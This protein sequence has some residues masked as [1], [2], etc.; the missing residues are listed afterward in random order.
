MAISNSQRT[1]CLRIQ[2]ADK[3][4]RGLRLS[5]EN[6]SDVQ[7]L[8]AQGL[9]KR[10]KQVSKNVISNVEHFSITKAGINSL[11]IVNRLE[12]MHESI[13]FWQSNF[14]GILFRISKDLLTKDIASVYR[15]IISD[16]VRQNIIEDYQLSV[17]YESF[18]GGNAIRLNPKKIGNDWDGLEKT[19]WVKTYRYSL[20]LLKAFNYDYGNVQMD[21]NSAVRFYGGYC[22]NWPLVDSVENKPEANAILVECYGSIEAGI[23]TVKFY[24]AEAEAKR[25][26]TSQSK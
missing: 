20:S 11:K 6:Q 15:R 16:L 24:M 12:T 14:E 26:S 19:S 13:S 4:S 25:L 9:L 8:L 21:Y 18:S 1:L 7:I 3:V 22:R 23:K 2:K 17:R 10:K 5:A